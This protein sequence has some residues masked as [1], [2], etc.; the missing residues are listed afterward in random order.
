MTMKTEKFTVTLPADLKQQV[1][2]RAEHEHRNVSNMTMVLL[3][4][5]LEKREKGKEKAA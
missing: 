2:N 1:K 4:E 3:L 5:A